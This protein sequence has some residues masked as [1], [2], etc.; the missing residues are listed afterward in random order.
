MIPLMAFGRD[1]PLTLREQITAIVRHRRDTLVADLAS[2]LA[3]EATL[4]GDRWTEVAGI[5]VSLLAT[6]IQTGEP[7]SHGAATH[8]LAQFIPPLTVRQLVRAMYS[9]E[10]TLLDELALSDVI[11]A[12]SDSWPAVLHGVR[13]AMVEAAGSFAD[14]HSS[15][16]T[17]RDPLTTLISPQVFEY[18]LGKEVL[19]ALRHA[20]GIAVLLFD[21]DDLQRLNES[22]GY[23]TG[24][25]L[26]ERLGILARSYFRT[27]DW[28]S[29]Q[30][31]DSIAVMLPETTLDQAA[32][33]ATRFRQMVRQRLILVD[34][35]TES[36]ATVTV[37]AAAVGTD[38]VNA[39][40]NPVSIVTEAEA[41]AMRAKMN[42]G[43]RV[44]TVAL[45]PTALT[46]AGT[47]SVLGISPRE[48]VR[49]IRGGALRATR[50]GRHL[51]IPRDQIEDYRKKA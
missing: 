4:D 16:G 25:R 10:R 33:L 15:L 9:A 42:G 13:A 11:G 26:L 7:D 22:H 29:R 23:G 19:R 51:H 2:G 44:E 37:S 6:T 45:L 36:I 48:V 28:V 31:G 3:G 1:L 50:R 24:D 38:L 41:A 40:L 18:A 5:L 49:L 43:D 35:K 17:L 30:G 47:A 46:I 12:T 27:H 20:H 32:L 39:P 21:I 8:E 34:H 14:G